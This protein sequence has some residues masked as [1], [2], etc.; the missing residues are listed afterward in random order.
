PIEALAV[1]AELR[2]TGYS[3]SS[4]YD[5][6]A[7]VK[8]KFAGPAFLSAGYRYEAIDIDEKDILAD[9]EFSGPFAEVGFEL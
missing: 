1:E 2:G 6:I 5:L 4:Y 7:R 8:Y 9:I 3:G